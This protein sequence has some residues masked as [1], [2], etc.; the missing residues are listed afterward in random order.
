LEKDQALRFADVSELAAA[1]VPF[2]SPKAESS[3]R[4]IQRVLSALPTALD[5]SARFSSGERTVIDSRREVVNPVGEAAANSTRAVGRVHVAALDADSYAT[6]LADPLV[7]IGDSAAEP[8]ISRR[9]R[10]WPAIAVGAA[11]VIVVGV[12]SSARLARVAPA[13]E[14][15]RAVTV[16]TP[17][18]TAGPVPQA[19]AA[20]PST[21]PVPGVPAAASVESSASPTPERPAAR[22]V[23]R[24]RPMANPSAAPPA[25]PAVSKSSAKAYDP[26]AAWDPNSFGPRR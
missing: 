10:V 25:Q 14:T 12:V 5:K 17:A 8:P 19:P 4:R 24:P 1:L 2:G 6:L 3:L 18:V 7:T 15:A 16:A 9:R 22:R 20:R 23:R 26:A 11:V 21:E 13:A